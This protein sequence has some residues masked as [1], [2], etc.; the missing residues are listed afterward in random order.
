MGSIIPGLENHVGHSLFG[1]FVCLFFLPCFKF[2]MWKFTLSRN[3]GGSLCYAHL[4]INNLHDDFAVVLGNLESEAVVIELTERN[5]VKAMSWKSWK[6]C[7]GSLSSWTWDTT[8]CFM[9]S[10]QSG[11]EW[12][13]QG[14]MCCLRADKIQWILVLNGALSVSSNKIYPDEN[15]ATYFFFQ[16]LQRVCVQMN[17][18]CF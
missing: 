17:V 1:L 12:K 15:I 2:M 11:T 6:P 4:D 7:L 5:T 8:E 14:R 10:L 3:R 18:I 13:K 9:C 16:G